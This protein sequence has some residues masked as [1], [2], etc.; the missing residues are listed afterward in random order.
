MDFHRL[1]KGMLYISFSRLYHFS[2]LIYLYGVIFFENDRLFFWNINPDDTKLQWNVPQGIKHWSVS[3][4]LIKLLLWLFVNRFYSFYFTWIN[5]NEKLK[6]KLQV[7]V[8]LSLSS[9][10]HSTEA[11]PTVAPAAADNFAFLL[12]SD[13]LTPYKMFNT[14]ICWSAEV[15]L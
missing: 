14:S 13:G 1:Y 4:I 11:L 5:H 15:L 12:P 7:T 10:E 3:V 8:F 2:C 9:V 6:E